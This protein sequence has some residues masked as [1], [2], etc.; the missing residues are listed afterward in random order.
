MEVVGIID[1]KKCNQFED[2]A[3]DILEWKNRIHTLVGQGFDDDDD[4]I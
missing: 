3:E 4:G 2:L 1:M